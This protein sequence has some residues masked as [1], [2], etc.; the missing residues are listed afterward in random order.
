MAV[1]ISMINLCFE[2][3]ITHPSI[4]GPVALISWEKSPFLKTE[5][6]PQVCETSF[7]GLNQSFFKADVESCHFIFQ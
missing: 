3:L 1:R 7:L 6:S 2:R 4:L 5:F